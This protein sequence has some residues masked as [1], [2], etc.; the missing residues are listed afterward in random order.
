MV[1]CYY[2]FDWQAAYWVATEGL[3]LRP[4][5]IQ[6]IEHLRGCLEMGSRASDATGTVYRAVSVPLDIFVGYSSEKRQK[7][8]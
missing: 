2:Q 6:E 3:K 8:W 5:I 7:C 4:N 1:L